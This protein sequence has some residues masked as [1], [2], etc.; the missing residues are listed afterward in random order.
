MIQKKQIVFIILTVLWCCLIFLFSSQ[1]SNESSNTSAKLITQ[2]CK[3]VYP[4]FC[5]LSINEQEQVIDNFQFI[6]R[7]TAHFSAYAV[8]G[9]LAYQA[10]PRLKRTYTMYLSAL[11]FSFIYA[12][13]D[14]FHQ[15]FVP[16]RSCEFRD[17]LIDTC[18]ACFGIMISFL[19]SKLIFKIK[20]NRTKSS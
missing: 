5:Q 12:C 8:L 2:V 10:L 3:A 19:I 15:K 14:E 11:T 1:N 6:A 20:S 9:A 16:G 7:K 13:T 17:V 18:G 4:N